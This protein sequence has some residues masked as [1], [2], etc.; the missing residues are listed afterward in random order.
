MRPR[1]AWLLSALA[2]CGAP[3]CR[4]T[5]GA[6]NAHDFNVLI[7]VLDAC[8]A[9]KLGCYGFERDSSP[10]LDALARD[11]DAAVFR[12]HYVQG[13]W[14]K[15][16]TASL[17]TGLYVF[18]HKVLTDH[19]RGEG[20]GK[21]RLFRTQILPERYETLAERFRAAGFLTFG[22]VKS[23][24]LA[25]EYGFEQGFERYHLPR[26]VKG[27]RARVEK[28]LELVRAAPPRRF[29]GYLHL[30]ACHNPFPKDERSPAY[31]ERYG[32]PYDEA[33]R[34]AEGVDFGDIEIKFA[35]REKR[36]RVTPEDERF[37]HLVY[38]AKLRQADETSFAALVRGL[39]AAG[40]YDDTLILVTADH[41]EELL[42]HGGYH[43]GYALWEELAHVP[44][45]VKYPK[46]RR[47]R[48]VGPRVDALT[49]SIDVLP[50][51]LA[52]SGLPQDAKLPGEP[53][54]AG[55]FQP[56]ALVEIKGGGWARVQDGFKLIVEG[57]GP[58]LYDLAGDPGETRDLAAREPARVAALLEATRRLRETLGEGE[59]AP[60]IDTELD[61]E[62][63]ESLRSLGY[64][65]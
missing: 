46:G 24:Q 30:T 13:T 61:A 53:A 35:L 26:E 28:A 31:L 47:P 45:V 50:S 22:V 29:L 40:R 19:Q 42:D 64:V 14:T 6:A 15:P 58:R 9:D 51:L 23:Q 5:G 27:D 65:R 37:L 1:W 49:Q 4:A 54:L 63:L 16:S 2:L 3:G 38:E 56:F 12:R 43:H 33:A 25:S 60:S 32:F 52:L 44:L 10:N 11:P 41:G 7:V 39:K 62:A 55:S 48:G 36:V 8:R 57:E 17:F 20:G 34:A 21:R 59:E 18:Q